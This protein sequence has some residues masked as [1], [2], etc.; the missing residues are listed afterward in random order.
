MKK[1][2]IA[3]IAGLAYYWVARSSV[4][5]TDPQPADAAYLIANSSQRR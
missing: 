5:L 1:I 2:L 3:S 4:G